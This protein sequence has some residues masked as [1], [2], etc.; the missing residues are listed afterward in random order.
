MKNRSNLEIKETNN[1]DV[2]IFGRNKDIWLSD[3]EQII[4]EIT[5]V[6]IP[7]TEL[8]EPQPQT[9]S[10]YSQ[11]T[12][13]LDIS[14]PKDL[15]GGK[16]IV[17]IAPKWEIDATVSID[18]SGRD[19]LQY[20]NDKDNPQAVKYY[21]AETFIIS[22][23]NNNTSL[24]SPGLSFREQ[25]INA[26]NSNNSINFLDS[27]VTSAIT[28]GVRYGQPYRGPLP[29]DS[30]D[31]GP[32]MLRCPITGKEE[33]NT[34]K[35]TTSTGYYMNKEDAQII[36]N[37]ANSAFENFFSRHQRSK[38]KLNYTQYDGMNSYKKHIA[39]L[40]TELGSGIQP[41]LK[42]TTA[43]V[44]VGYV[45]NKKLDLTGSKGADGLPGLPG[46]PGGSG[47]NFLGIGDIIIGKEKL[48]IVSDGGKGGPGQ[49]GG[50][51][52]EGK[53]G[54]DAPPLSHSEFLNV[55][56][57]YKIAPY[58]KQ[59]ISIWWKGHSTYEQ[60]YK[61][62][63]LDD[64]GQDNSKGGIGGDGSAGGASGKGGLPGSIELYDKSSNSSLLSFQNEAGLAGISGV[65][66][67]PGA[68]GLHGNLRHYTINYI[69][70]E[71]DGYDPKESH[72]ID[73]T[74]RNK[75]GAAWLSGPNDKD[76]AFPKQ[77]VM[78][79]YQ[80]ITKYIEFQLDTLNANQQ[81]CIKHD[82]FIK[83]TRQIF[84]EQTVTIEDFIERLQFIVKLQ[85]YQYITTENVVD[86]Y[87]DF[88]ADI[89]RATA[90]SSFNQKELQIVYTAAHSGVCRLNSSKDIVMVTDLSKYFT[91]IIADINQLEKIET[92]VVKM[93]YQ[94][95]YE[96]NYK[97]K[98]TEAKSLI[99]SLLKALETQE[100]DLTHN[101]N[102]V[103]K[104]IEE[105]K[106]QNHEHTKQLLAQKDQLVY[107]SV[108]S[109]ILGIVN[110]GAQALSFAGPVGKIAGTAISA[111]VGI[112]SNFM[113]EV[114]VNVP[115]AFYSLIDTIGNKLDQD[116]KLDKVKS[117][118]AT[119][120]ADLQN[121]GKAKSGVK[122]LKDLE[123]LAD[124]DFQKLQEKW[125]IMINTPGMQVEAY[126]QINKY[127][128][129]TKQFQNDQLNNSNIDDNAKTAIKKK[130]DEINVLA[131]KYSEEAKKAKKLEDDSAT[132]E[133]MQVGLYTL[134]AALDVIK[135]QKIYNDKIGQVNDLLKK[136]KA[137]DTVLE[138]KK[139]DMLAL[140]NDTIKQMESEVEKLLKDLEGQS[141]AYLTFRQW[142]TD[143]YLNW[144]KDLLNDQTQ[145]LKSNKQL[146][147]TCKQIEN[148]IKTVNKIHKNI[149]SQCE[150]IELATYIHD[151]TSGDLD[152]TKLPH[153]KE[154]LE[155]RQLI[156]RDVIEE[157]YNKAIT[158]FDQIMFPF[159][160]YL[161][162]AIDKATPNPNHALS[163]SEKLSEIQKQMIMQDAVVIPKIDNDLMYSS[164]QNA[165]GY[166]PF[167]TWSYRDYPNEI[168]D[169]LTQGKAV[170]LEADIRES[171]HNGYAI[172]FEKISITVT[173]N[174]SPELNKQLN[175]NLRPF[176]VKMQHSGISHYK[177][178]VDQ[179]DR[180]FIKVVDNDEIIFTENYCNADDVK[181]R[182]VNFTHEK[183]SGKHD[184]RTKLT[185]LSPYTSWNIQLDQKSQESSIFKEIANLIHGHENDIAI[186]LV[187]EGFYF[188]SKSSNFDLIGDVWGDW[189]EM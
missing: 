32:H 109:F 113:P 183:Y 74:V 181:L 90:I 148:I 98:T 21:I 7:Q 48:K 91:Q 50:N 107:L 163:P 37:D 161:L 132:L 87:Q 125:K 150:E 155:T 146:M 64:K 25:K 166:Q 143:R 168:H 140:K 15:V 135:T 187:G 41:N 34:M 39:E 28:P 43:K 61:L 180:C 22:D 11:D 78:S 129:D 33:H 170:S 156:Q 178:K 162:Q 171:K 188:D 56:K 19:Q 71:Y 29:S 52:H 106:E 14:L 4:K 69:C 54:N 46:L 108:C 81:P 120:D 110:V 158:A 27:F 51:G 102:S 175:E 100:S 99:D 157:H 40:Q 141:A 89:Q 117:N 53:K 75:I 38:S 44:Y 138:A 104:D 112:A 47:G 184:K 174:D 65:N 95:S 60:K 167:V 115:K 59:D 88:K 92:T 149:Q 30:I 145:G 165:K 124:Q 42:H 3:V 105:L 10:I 123:V 126:R 142:E 131:Q 80:E 67:N 177:W 128:K 94:A 116:H 137:T 103:I 114:Q 68:G 118:L 173:V 72:T 5:T 58:F 31:T 26:S 24:T 151:I 6:P 79:S 2:I 152:L 73:N 84:N 127:I 49:N 20:P 154:I 82:E 16:N 172:R 63:S 70:S 144:L 9:I 36:I 179:Q 122:T 189:V 86:F 23:T 17:I 160:S 176:D 76:I 85:G 164:F 8:A 134:N 83:Y 66:G 45:E 139:E 121:I 111:G 130:I 12:I 35:L 169:L 147:N 18:L 57:E 136:N 101:M 186:H 96:N 119:L 55:I 62:T 133:K 182:S 97:K 153:S 93:S 77:I 1:N 159:T 13:H 185:Q